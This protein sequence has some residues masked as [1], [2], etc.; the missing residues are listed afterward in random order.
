MQQTLL[1]FAAARYG[2]DEE[3]AKVG[4]IMCHWQRRRCYLTRK[5][6]AKHCSVKLACE[7][8]W[9]QGVDVVTYSTRSHT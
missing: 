7:R 5:Q 4:V 3:A 9:H 2:E 6:H 1:F 8:I